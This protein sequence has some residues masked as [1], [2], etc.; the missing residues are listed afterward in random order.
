MSLELY[1]L[2]FADDQEFILAEI[3]WINNSGESK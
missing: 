1:Q 2:A 3:K